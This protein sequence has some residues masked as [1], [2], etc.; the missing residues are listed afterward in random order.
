MKSPTD[1]DEFEEK[2]KDELDKERYMFLTVDEL[3]FEA[4][5]GMLLFYI[6]KYFLQCPMLLTNAFLHIEFVNKRSETSVN[7][8]YTVYKNAACKHCLHCL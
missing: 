7:I 4:Y 2:I 8:V 1:V 5:L 6:S 3:E